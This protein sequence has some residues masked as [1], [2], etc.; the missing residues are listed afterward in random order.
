MKIY[1]EF[2]LDLLEVEGPYKRSISN[3]VFGMSILIKMSLKMMGIFLNLLTRE[4]L[5]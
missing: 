5:Q 1:K 4:N 2:E 3:I